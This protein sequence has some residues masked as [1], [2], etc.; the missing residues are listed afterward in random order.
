MQEPVSARKRGFQGEDIARRYLS[1][2]GYRILESNF[3]SPYG[4]IDIIAQ[5][6]NNLVFIEVK[7]RAI[8]D[9]DKAIMSIGKSKQKRIVQTALHYIATHNDLEALYSRFD[10]IVIFGKKDDP[11][12]EIRHYK[13][14]FYGESDY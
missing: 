5:D 2:L 13:D 9:I 14:A 3:Y 12:Y 8:H 4:E 7:L 10:A 6:G 11:H 1:H